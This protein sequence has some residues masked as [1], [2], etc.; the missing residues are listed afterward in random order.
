MILDLIV[1]A[2]DDGY[3]AEI[4]SLHG[5]DAWAHTE[6]EVMEK[7]LE[8]AV[9]YLKV[10]SPKKFKIDLARKEKR[11]FIYKLIFDKP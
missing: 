8:Q 11:K 2:T 7:I 6:E 9:Y 4:P 5:C 3:T 1:R 10:E